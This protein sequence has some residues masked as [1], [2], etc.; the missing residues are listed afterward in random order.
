MAGSGMDLVPFLLKDGKWKL[1]DRDRGLILPDRFDEMKPAKG[2]AIFL[3]NDKSWTV[4]NRQGKDLCNATFLNVEEL[5]G[6]LIYGYGS[7]NRLYFPDGKEFPVHVVKWV[8]SIGK[9]KDKLVI[10]NSDDKVGICDFKGNVLLPFHYDYAPTLYAEH[11]YRVKKQVGNKWKMG[12]TDSAFHEVVPCNYFECGLFSQKLFYAMDE[13]GSCDLYHINGKKFIHLNQFTTE[14]YSTGNFMV[15]HVGDESLEVSTYGGKFFSALDVRYKMDSDYIIL[16]RDQGDALLFAN[17]KISEWKGKSISNIS[18][19]RNYLSISDKKSK[20]KNQ[21]ALKGIIDLNGKQIAEEQFYE[22]RHAAGDRI[23]VGQ[24]KSTSGRMKILFGIYDVKKKKLIVD[25]NYEEVVIFANGSYALYE[26]KKYHLYQSSGISRS[27]SYDQ[28]YHSSLLMGIDSIAF[29]S[30]KNVS[31]DKSGPGQYLMGLLDANGEEFIAPE[32]E[33]IEQ[34]RGYYNENFPK[35]KLYY[36]GSKNMNGKRISALYN[37]KL[38]RITDFS[39][40][41]IHSYFKG[42]MIAGI[43]TDQQNVIRQRIIDTKGNPVFPVDF[44]RVERMTDWGLVAKVG[45]EWQMWNWDRKLIGKFNGTNAH[46]FFPDY[47]RLYDK[48]KNGIMDLN[49]KIILPCIYDDVAGVFLEGTIFKVKMN[50]EM[51]YT[52]ASQKKY[53]E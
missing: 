33:N 53:M 37:Y 50:N 34:I 40:S 49:G 11:Y 2:N 35:E 47:I 12:L 21:V 36:Y 52:D 5:D 45:D 46:W 32:L 15:R 1:Y 41:G 13:D 39:F 28:I 42:V 20:L 43:Y 17:G 38:K 14:Y 29:Y 3:R 19:S 9:Q 16:E 30:C 7:V 24:L 22:I 27:K 6:G 10:C 48:G 51:Y 18:N 4:I 31:I 44:D 23:V 8:F 25:C 26:N